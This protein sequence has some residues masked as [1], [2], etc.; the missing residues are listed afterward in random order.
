MLRLHLLTGGQRI[1]RVRSGVETLLAAHGISRKVRGHLQSHGIGG[2]QARHYDG[3][4]YMR[5]KHDALTLLMRHLARP[6]RGRTGPKHGSAAPTAN[7]PPRP[8]VD[9]RAPN[10]HAVHTAPIFAYE[11]DSPPPACLLEPE[12][13]RRSGHIRQRDCCSDA[14]GEVEGMRDRMR[15]QCQDDHPRRD[16]PPC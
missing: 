14:P 2:V 8:R 3:H 6:S 12:R 9:S 15:P 13:H 10:A 5:E 7:L 11:L 1:Q 16:T 4:D